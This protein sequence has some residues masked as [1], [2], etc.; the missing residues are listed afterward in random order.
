[1]PMDGAPYISIGS[2]ETEAAL[3]VRALCLLPLRPGAMA[4]LSHL[5][6]SGHSL[7][8]QHVGHMS[9]SRPPK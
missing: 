9:R 7:R 1:M 8:Q 6:R 4:A 2:T 5:L 3:F